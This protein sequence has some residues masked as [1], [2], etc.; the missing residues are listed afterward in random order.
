MRYARC[1]KQPR[2]FAQLASQHGFLRTA[3]ETPADWKALVTRLEPIGAL[4]TEPAAGD[5]A[6]PGPG[7]GAAIA[8]AL[9]SMQELCQEAV[10]RGDVAVGANNSLFEVQ[11]RTLAGLL[12]LQAATDLELRPAFRRCGYCHEWFAVSGRLDQLYCVAQHRHAARNDKRQ[13]N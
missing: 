7:Y 3:T 12:I 5:M 1:K 2:A 13:E 9:A 10:S 6:P 11:P 4:W 8:S